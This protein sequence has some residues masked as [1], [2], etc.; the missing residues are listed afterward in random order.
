MGSWSARGPVATRV[1]A[2]LVADIF[3]GNLIATLEFDVLDAGG[4]PLSVQPKKAHPEHYA[5]RIG[6][7][8]RM[9]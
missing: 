7:G 5:E 4:T 8:G 9:I 3:G 2:V 1:A 6:G